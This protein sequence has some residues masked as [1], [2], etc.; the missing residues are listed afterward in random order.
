MKTLYLH[1]GIP[2]TAS[3]AIQMFLVANEKVLNAHGYTYPDFGLSYSY[4]SDRRNGHFMIGEAFGIKGERD[5]TQDDQ[6]WEDCFKKINKL[7]EKYDNVILSDEGFWRQGVRYRGRI[8]KKI[9]EEI[10]KEQFAVKVVVYLRRQDQYLYSRWNQQLKMAQ[11]LT[12]PNYTQTW[13]EMLDANSGRLLD[14][15]AMLH[16]IS[17]YVGKENIIVRRFDRKEF[18]GQ[19]VYA[20]FLHAVGLEFS[21][22][23]QI[24]NETPN[25][26]LTKNN[27]EI[28][29]VLNGLPGLDETCN[30]VFRQC[31]SALSELPSDDSRYSMFSEQEMY[32]FMSRFEEGN[33]RI[34]REYFDGEQEL[35]E[36]SYKA[37]EKWQRDN[38]AMLED[39]IKFTGSVAVYL[40]KENEKLKKELK[41]Q[42]GI[43]EKYQSLTEQM[44]HLVKKPVKK[45]KR[46]LW[47]K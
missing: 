7:F 1:I 20:D 6:I 14:F 45:V 38:P 13:E 35:F 40:I 21:D 10:Q 23:F 9:R 8:W 26:S 43:S 41:E 22:E 3:T 17:K 33:N 29:R 37:E 24:E 42:R 32:D 5:F 16:T 30:T 28:K 39:L 2:K 12:S 11:G 34:A 36:V 18:Y 4:T 19:T 46:T 25:V 15:D 27:I 44:A 47:G 31:L